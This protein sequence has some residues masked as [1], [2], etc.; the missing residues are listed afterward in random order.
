MAV[1]PSGAT[2]W[3][4][5][6]DCIED[7]EILSF[8]IAKQMYSVK[9]IGETFFAFHN[10]LFTHSDHAQ[11][12]RNQLVK[13]NSGRIAPKPLARDYDSSSAIAHPIT[14]VTKRPIW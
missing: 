1:I 9:G 14:K 10:E 12:R 3:Y 5:Y 11:Q 2:R 7:V 4:A 6:T 13:M 8:D